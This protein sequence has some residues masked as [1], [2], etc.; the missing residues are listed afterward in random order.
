MAY[1]MKGPTFFNKKSPMK[2]ER[3]DNAKA[4]AIQEETK[5]KRNARVIQ[6]NNFGVFADKKRP[7]A[8][9]VEGDKLTKE[10]S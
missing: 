2:S 8:G 3:L 7:L 10:L 5:R 4:A 9:S 6:D 1:K